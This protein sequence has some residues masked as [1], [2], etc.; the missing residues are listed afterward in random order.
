MIKESGSGATLSSGTHLGLE[1]FM[2]GPL[3]AGLRAFKSGS[4]KKWVRLGLNGRKFDPVQPGPNI[5]LSVDMS[6]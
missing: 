3:S 2:G 1:V 4:I 6:K 5:W